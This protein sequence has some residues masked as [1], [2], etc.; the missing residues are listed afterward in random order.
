MIHNNILLLL[1]ITTL[2][3]SSCRH[4]TPLSSESV[5][6]SAYQEGEVSEVDQ[7]IETHLTKPYNISVEYRWDKHSSQKDSYSY[8]PSEE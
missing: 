4:E 5:L 1:I 2:L 7:W 6:S 8:P 3:A